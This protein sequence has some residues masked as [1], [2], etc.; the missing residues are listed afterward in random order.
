MDVGNQRPSFREPQPIRVPRQ[1]ECVRCFDPVAGSPSDD[2]CGTCL[3]E[4][5]RPAPGA[6][7]DVETMR[8][9][10]RAILDIHRPLAADGRLCAEGCAGSYPCTTSLEAR[11]GLGLSA[12][13]S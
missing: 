11:H 2:W 1:T 9:A 7:R 10:L 8:E 3:D 13:G 6:D 4:L 12:P 5:R